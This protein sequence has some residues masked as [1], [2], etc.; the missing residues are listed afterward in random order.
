MNTLHSLADRWPRLLLWLLALSQGLAPLPSFAQD[1]DIEQFDLDELL[2]TQVS[3]ATRSKSVA[4][5][6]APGIVTIITR[7]QIQQAA[8][9]DLMDALSMVPGFDFGVDTFGSTLPAV[10]GLW[11][12]E[13]K[14]LILID[15]HEL[16]ENMYLTT[17]LG[18]RISMDWVERIELVRGPGAAMYGGAAEY[19]VVNVVS[20]KAN[21]YSGLAV[22]ASYG[23]FLDAW[24]SG[25]ASFG[26]AY[27]RR[28][29]SLSVA[30]QLAQG[31]LSFYAHLHA[32][33]GQRS[34]QVY[35]DYEGNS[36]RMLGQSSLDP[37]ALNAGVES[38]SW[39]LRYYL[40]RYHL[41]QRDGYDLALPRAFDADI[42]QSSLIA[43]THWQVHPDWRLEAELRHGWQRPWRTVDPASRELD[44]IY[45]DPLVHQ[46]N[47]Q[48][49]THW[50]AVE[51]LKL[52]AGVAYN[53]QHASEPEY[54]FADPEQP[55]V[56]RE[57]VTFHNLA[58]WLQA[59]FEHPWVNISG[60]L[61]FELHSQ[62]GES[63]APRL[64]LSRRFGE[65][66]AKLLASQAFRVPSLI[67][68]GLS[69]NLQ[70]ERSTAFELELGYQA[71]D[72][73][74]FAISA[75]DISTNEP[76]LYFYD[77]DN[78]TEQYVNGESLGSSGFELEARFRRPSLSAWASYAFYTPAL[79]D[80][81]ERFR[82]PGHDDQYLGF[83][84]HVLRA[85]ID[86]SLLESIDLHLDARLHSPRH[87]IDG[88]DENEE[89][90]YRKLDT[91]LALNAAISFRKLGIDGLG[92]RLSGHNLLG[93]A[94]DWVQPFDGGH[95]PLPSPAQ[96][97][98]L[99]LSFETP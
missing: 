92:L 95:A 90:S 36:Y 70:S 55:E 50:D 75:F 16:H 15:G 59:L 26:D 47:A 29:L 5:R 99:H 32:G 48:V 68:L 10:R 2:D 66:H 18:N 64:A 7:E 23:Q 88:Y 76:I 51:Q 57:E 27:A 52:T 54:G 97:V 58:T 84:P 65:L 62:F 77:S 49:Q 89:P 34:D 78:D 67:N 87:A 24:S 72:D 8:A 83:S 73:L 9:R 21:H 44:G 25:E 37:L 45:F 86:Y 56:Y 98:T 69:P 82:V 81:D 93:A 61:R 42:L 60:G 20:R 53:L 94:L 12:A 6:D 33:Q 4:A 28:S 17:P 46:F 74:Y 43:G 40:E 19:A 91:Q 85:G 3:V 41:T 39:F 35:T 80:G 79:H 13:G 38:E 31:E 22:S 96:E 71:R 30:E 1:L 11:A 63:F 14:V